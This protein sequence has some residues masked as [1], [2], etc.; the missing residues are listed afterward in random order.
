MVTTKAKAAA[1]I[2]PRDG[3][4][5]SDRVF[6]VEGSARDGCADAPVLNLMARCHP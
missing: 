3:A 5:K 1:T 6:M 4:L 2:S